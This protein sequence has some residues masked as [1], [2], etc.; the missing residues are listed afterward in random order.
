MTGAN[1]MSWKL[2]F[3][4]ISCLLADAF[5]FSVENFVVMKIF[6]AVCKSYCFSAQSD[7]SCRKVS[8]NFRGRKSSDKTAIRL[9]PWCYWGVAVEWALILVREPTEPAN[10]PWFFS[11]KHLSESSK[12]R[13]KAK[14]ADANTAERP[15]CLHFP[16]LDPNNAVAVAPNLLD[17]LLLPC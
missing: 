6:Y 15:Q 9:W 10:L 2:F 3:L 8:N 7:K 5:A 4:K 17:Q 13:G 11:L 16:L 1:Y 14:V 12:Q